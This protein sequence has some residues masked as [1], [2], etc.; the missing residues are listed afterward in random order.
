MRSHRAIEKR[1]RRR[2]H[3][4]A[5]IAVVAASCATVLAGCGSSGKPTGTGASAT[6]PGVKFANCM[7]A[8]GVS[9]FPDP[10]AGGQ[11]FIG[12]GSGI[13]PQ[14]PSFQAAQKACGQGPG[15]PAPPKMT[16]SQKLAAIAFAKCMRKHGE[17]GFPDPTLTAP[18]GAVRVLVLRGMVFAFTGAG[19]DPMSPAFRQAAAACGVKLPTGPPRPSGP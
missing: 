15:G 16:E 11:N 3:G 1:G 8:H 9:H 13:D 5:A 18:S 6:D 4:G 7:R 10:G 2:R 12:P 19:I 14:S 17:S